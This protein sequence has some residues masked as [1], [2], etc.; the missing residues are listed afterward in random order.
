MH[1]HSGTSPAPELNALVADEASLYK[2]VIVEDFVDAYN[3][4]TIKSIMGLKW[5]AQ[6][7]GNAKY[8]F[9]VDDDMFVNTYNLLR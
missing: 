7:C 1:A 9:K 6:Y 4:L 3:N 5:A 8:V 2:D